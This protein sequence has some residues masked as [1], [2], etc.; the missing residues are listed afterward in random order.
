MLTHFS[1]HGHL[2]LQNNL[3]ELWALLNFLYPETFIS[4]KSFDAAFD[5]AT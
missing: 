3:H 4:S 5:L 2:P 1:H